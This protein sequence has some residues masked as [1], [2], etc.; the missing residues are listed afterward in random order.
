MMTIKRVLKDS[1]EDAVRLTRSEKM[2]MLVLAYADTILDEL[3]TDMADRLKMVEGGAET[4]Q[5]AA[6]KVDWLL[7]ELRLTVPMNQRM[8]L[9]NTAADYDV[10]MTPKLTPGSTNVIM[11]KEEFR[12]LVECAREKCKVCTLDDEECEGCELFRLLTS[13]LPMDDYHNGM[14][15]AYNLAGW[16]N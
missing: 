7:N 11:E 12:G 6:E 2:S 1:R 10:R 3:R 14:L 15:C 13:V 16:G 9:Q 5:E 8:H 4:L